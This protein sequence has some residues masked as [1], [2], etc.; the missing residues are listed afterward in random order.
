MSQILHITYASW[1]VAAALLVSATITPATAQIQGPPG[2]N[3]FCAMYNDSSTLDCSFGT[4]AEC[5]AAISGVGGL[6]QAN[7]IPQGQQRFRGFPQLIPTDP[8]GLYR[9][10]S[11]GLPPVPPPP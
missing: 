9:D 10:Q 5:Q 6:C 8:L 1:A 11:Q 4:F 3:S 7:N 2:N